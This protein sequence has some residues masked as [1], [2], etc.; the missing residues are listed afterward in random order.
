M[1]VVILPYYLF[2]HIPFIL[3]SLVHLLENKS[4]RHRCYKRGDY[5]K[6]ICLY[7]NLLRIRVL[8]TLT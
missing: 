7:E 4:Y 3:E 5:N 6:F 8:K 1:D 2:M